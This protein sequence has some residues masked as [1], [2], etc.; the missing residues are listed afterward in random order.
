[1][2]K[3]LHKLNLRKAFLIMIKI[4]L[5]CQKKKNPAAK[6]KKDY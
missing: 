5:S 2:G 4:Q 3:F 6:K 1:M